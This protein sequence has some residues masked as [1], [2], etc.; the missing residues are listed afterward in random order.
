MIVN[1]FKIMGKSTEVRSSS[2]DHI[3]LGSQIGSPCGHEC[4][5]DEAAT[6]F[7]HAA[8]N[9]HLMSIVSFA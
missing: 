4:M 7:R 1:W 9:N 8:E 5:L 3:P 6:T 2:P